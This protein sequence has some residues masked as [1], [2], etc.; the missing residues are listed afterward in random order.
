M[1]P[2]EVKCEICGNIVLKSQTLS[3]KNGGRACR[4]HEGTQ[5]Q[6]KQIQLQQKESLQKSIERKEKKYKPMEDYDYS[7]MTKKYNV[8]WKCGCEGTSLQEYYL[9]CAV[10]MEKINMVGAEWNFFDL[11]FQIKKFISKEHQI[12]L[13]RISI[14]NKPEV[15]EKIKYKNRLIAKFVGLIQVCPECLKRVGLDEEWKDQV[16]KNMPKIDL[17]TAYLFG[18][19]LKPELTKMAVDQLYDEHFG[20]E[21][22]T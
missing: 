9:Q 7:S 19:L 5:E 22:T 20:S 18:S 11:P 16:R 17:K 8:C 15:I 2:K 14:K 10:A 6:S 13:I 21:K 12:P 3:I 1:P 4:E